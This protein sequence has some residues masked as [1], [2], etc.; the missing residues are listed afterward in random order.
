VVV[1]K[2]PSS[3]SS[4]NRFVR[5]VVVALLLIGAM[6]FYLHA[7]L[8]IFERRSEPPVAESD[9]DKAGPAN[10]AYLGGGE[11][12]RFCD[13]WRP[14]AGNGSIVFIG[15]SQGAG[16]RDHGPGY[17]E[18]VAGRLECAGNPELVF[19]LHVGGANSYEQGLILLT[20]LRSGTT[21]RAVVWS[22]SI[23]SQRKN[24]IRSEY[25]L[26][27]EYVEDQLVAMSTTVMAPPS[28]LVSD[29]D[30][31]LER[32]V[33]ANATSQWDGIVSRTA[34]VRF[35]RRS[36]WDKGEILRRS[37]IGK[38]L[39]GKLRPG[40]ARQFDPPASILRESARFVGEI[41]GV[42]QAHGV[43]V[44]HVIAPIN[45]AAS[46]R[47]F[48]VRAEQ[49]CYPALREAADASG[50]QFMDLLDAMPPARFGT[51]DDGSP[52]AFHLD[53]IAHAELAELLMV[54]L[55]GNT[56]SEGTGP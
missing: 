3:I 38:L 56:S 10:F 21:P 26:A 9:T 8:D 23:F 46:P 52:D 6:E 39:P 1:G 25:A 30:I 33:V 48:T 28:S 53:G 15:D 40:A 43:R 34:I 41:T 18:I 20:M 54:E 45:R 12:R 47:P 16:A 13:L 35:M 19:S 27:Y 22:H 42:L 29:S 55:C 44:I 36:L 37:P 11:P 17:P 50:A 31:G 32:Q 5:D 51:Y 14:K 4:S 7:A 49:V 24:E 2:F